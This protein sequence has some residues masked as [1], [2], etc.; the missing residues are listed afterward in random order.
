MLFFI[1]IINLLSTEFVENKN[2]KI[3]FKDAIFN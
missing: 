3:A 1:I 2:K